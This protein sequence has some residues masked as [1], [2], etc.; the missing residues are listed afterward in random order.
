MEAMIYKESSGEAM[1]YESCTEAMGNKNL[2]LCDLKASFNRNVRNGQSI[3]LVCNVILVSVSCVTFSSVK[4][5]SALIRG[6]DPLV[7]CTCRWTP[8][9]HWSFL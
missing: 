4:K 3:N 6:P 2:Y 9:Y 7:T 8:L 5:A 1:S